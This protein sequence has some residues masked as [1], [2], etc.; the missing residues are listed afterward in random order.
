MAKIVHFVISVNLEDKTKKI[1]DDTLTAVF[2]FGTAW[3]DE[4]CEWFNETPEE[5]QEALE[6]LND[7][8][9]RLGE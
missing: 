5:L 6:I 8:S 1:D 4:K 9:K 2:H 7:N 3:D